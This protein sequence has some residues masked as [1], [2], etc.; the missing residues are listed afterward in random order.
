MQTPKAMVLNPGCTL[1]TPGELWKNTNA[2]A[3][4]QAA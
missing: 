3:S 4:P 1:E 2:W